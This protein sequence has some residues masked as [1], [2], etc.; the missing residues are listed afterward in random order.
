[1][2]DTGG[3][4]GREERGRLTGRGLDTTWHSR[5]FVAETTRKSE[6]F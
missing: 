1:M 6:G 3:G 2:E 4:E 5:P